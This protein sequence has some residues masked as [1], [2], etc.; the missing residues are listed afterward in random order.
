MRGC[1]GSSRCAPLGQ[2]PLDGLLRR[3]RKQGEQPPQPPHHI[4][5]GGPGQRGGLSALTLGHDPTFRMGVAPSA[6]MLGLGTWCPNG[7]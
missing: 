4:R 7:G 3:A 6:I 1:W 2:S 5:G